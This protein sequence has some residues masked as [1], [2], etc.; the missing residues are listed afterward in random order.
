MNSRILYATGLV[1]LGVGN[2]GYGIAQYLAASASVFVVGIEIVVGL[3][4]CLIGV[5]TL[6]EDEEAGIGRLSPRMERLIGWLGLFLGTLLIV[7]TAI[8]FVS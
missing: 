8:L 5:V 3:G 6:R 7:L 2:L 4:L 1:T